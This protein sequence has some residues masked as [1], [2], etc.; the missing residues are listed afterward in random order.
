[1]AAADSCLRKAGHNQPWIVITDRSCGLREWAESHAAYNTF[2]ENEKPTQFSEASLNFFYQRDV[3]ATLLFYTRRVAPPL[4]GGLAVFNI[5]PSVL[6]DFP[7]MGA[8]RK[9]LLANSPVL[10]ATLHQVDLDLDTGPVIAQTKLPFPASRDLADAERI[11]F[12]Q[13]TWLTLVWR[14]AAIGAQLGS[15]IIDPGL[16]PEVREAFDELQHSL[17][18]DVLEPGSN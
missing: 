17:G 5:H 11:S 16:P 10:G 12:L 6:P 1:L 13:K 3:K 9:A 18:L 14:Q 8:V 4:I 7:G 15:P 2:I